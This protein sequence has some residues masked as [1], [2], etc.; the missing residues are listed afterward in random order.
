MNEYNH[1]SVADSFENLRNSI[2]SATSCVLPTKKAMPVRKRYVSDRT[3]EL[4]DKRQSNYHL[5]N[6]AEREAASRD[7]RN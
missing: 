3:R 5:M 2:L 1:E 4:Y 6:K 7:L